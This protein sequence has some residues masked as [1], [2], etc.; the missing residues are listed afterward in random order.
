[1]N[2]FGFGCSNAHLVLDDAAS[3]LRSRNLR[4]NSANQSNGVHFAR[5]DFDGHSQK[6]NGCGIDSPDN[7]EASEPDLNSAR[8]EIDAEARHQIDTD[9]P[10][11]PKLI[12]L[13]S[14]SQAGLQS[15]IG[16]SEK[17]LRTTE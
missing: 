8:Q 4:G 2:A 1:M 10:W 14:T 15:Q 5:T 11:T 7:M 17:F 9:S 6:V 12:V 13:S 3:Y 16:A